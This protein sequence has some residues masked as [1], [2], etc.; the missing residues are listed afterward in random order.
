MTFHP[1]ASRKAA[2]RSMS[3]G[4][5]KPVLPPAPLSSQLVWL[6]LLPPI[7]RTDGPRFRNR[8]TVDTLLDAISPLTSAPLSMLRPAKPASTRSAPGIGA[9]IDTVTDAPVAGGLAC[10]A[11]DRVAS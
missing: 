5:T 2:R 1:L 4:A 6:T 3:A 11:A 9:P 8:F 10:T 7:R